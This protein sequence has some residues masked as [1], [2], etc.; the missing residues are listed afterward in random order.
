MR[1]FTLNTELWLPRSPEDVFPF[2]ADAHNLETITPPFLR[3]S[4]LTPAP[5]HMATGTLIDYR[6]R[7]RGVPIRWRTRIAA[8]E[9]PHRFIDEQLKGPYRLWHHEH[10]FMPEDGGTRCVDRVTYAVPG[11]PGLEGLIERGFVRRD[12]ERIFEYRRARLAELFTR[13]PSYTS[14]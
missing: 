13:L 12:V 7:L 4:V 3:F 5:I 8:W 11:G 2:F 9:P 10:L 14:A 6:L 1:T